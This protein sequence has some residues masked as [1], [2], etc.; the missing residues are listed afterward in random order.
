MLIWKTAC[1]QAHIQL[2]AAI[3][4]HSHCLL[5]FVHRNYPWKKPHCTQR[6]RTWNIM[7]NIND[8]IKELICDAFARLGRSPCFHFKPLGLSRHTTKSCVAICLLPCL[9]LYSICPS[10]FLMSPPCSRT[11]HDW[12]SLRTLSHLELYLHSP[13]ACHSRRRLRT[14]T[15]C[16]CVAVST[17][18]HAPITSMPP[19][20]SHVF[21]FIVLVSFLDISCAHDSFSNPW[22]LTHRRPLTHVA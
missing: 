18:P 2:Q 20:L 15:I 7:Q 8:C 4:A 13:A 12:H 22:R 14:T 19:S 5:L 11:F 21:M 10:S 6:R 16:Q 3:Q 1:I 9:L 17:P